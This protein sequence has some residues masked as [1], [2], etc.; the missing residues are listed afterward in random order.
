MPGNDQKRQI[1]NEIMHRY[2]SGALT[3]A[4]DAVR[5]ALRTTPHDL[6][7]LQLDGMI[8]AASNDH[9]RAIKQFR[10]ALAQKPDWPE[11]KFNLSQSLLAH[12]AYAEAITTLKNLISNQPRL[13][14]AHEALARCYQLQ[15][16]LPAA[17]DAYDA[18]LAMDPNQH[19]W[20]GVQALLRRQICDF[21]ARPPAGMLPPAAMVVLHDDPVL[22]KHA[23]ENYAAQKFAS[24]KPLAPRQP[25]AGERLKIGYLSADF[26][27]H[28]TAYLMA[29]LFA[30]HNRQQF[31]IFAYSYGIDDQS[32]IRQ[33]IR[34]TAD[35]FYDLASLTA[36]QAAQQIRSHAIDVLI[37]LKGYTAGGKLEILA[38]RP[39]PLQLH[40]L[41]FPGTLGAQFIDYFIADPVTV[42]DQATQH[43]REAILRLPGC[44]QINDRQRPIPAATT[45][46]HHQLPE[47]ALVL[48]SFNQTYKIT[49]EIF[50]LWLDILRELPDAVL[51]LYESN[52]HAPRALQSLAQTAGIDADRIIFAK[53][54]ELPQHLARYHH[55]DIA[56]DTAPVGGHTTTS[57]ALWMGTPVVTLT[58]QS[59]VARVAASLLHHAGLPELIAESPGQYKK[60]ILW[61]ARDAGERQRIRR[62][63]Q[64]NRLKLQLFDSPAFVR[65]LEAGLT[66]IWQRALNGQKPE[67]FDLPPLN[68]G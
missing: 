31:E 43:F 5:Q 38:Y 25:Q 67:T 64:D 37:D 1:F 59:F 58:G 39:A 32:A 36:L 12:K 49:P 34:N 47:H 50:A 24:L 17:I 57:D 65:G 8:A 33:R 22:Q 3:E 7:Y 30:L 14:M 28:A 60:L 4:A 51:W 13:A 63:L 29:E 6:N 62:H 52:R 45:R 20:C 48:G 27:T 68:G 16:D 54:T 41:G 21:T 44:Y 55:V 42:P 61:L 2:R 19:E 9:D 23:A 46:A 26:H 56:L 66:A 53:P 10:L 18:A 15:G 11:A 40:W 35:H